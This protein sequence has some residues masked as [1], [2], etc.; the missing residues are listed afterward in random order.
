MAEWNVGQE[1]EWLTRPTGNGYLR[2]I[3][4][5][6]GP[7]KVGIAVQSPKTGEWKAKWAESRYLRMI[8]A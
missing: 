4:V 6:S 2:G 7:C 8:K 5:K 1:V 3:V